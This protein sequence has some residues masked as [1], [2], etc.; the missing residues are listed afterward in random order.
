MGDSLSYLDNL[1]FEL[2]LD[3]KVIVFIGVGRRRTRKCASFYD[4]VE[5]FLNVFS[6]QLN[7]P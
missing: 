5:H 1:L 4:C 7:I 3:G 6:L 2:I